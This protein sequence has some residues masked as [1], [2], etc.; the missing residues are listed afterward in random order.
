MISLEQSP[1]L[2]TYDDI[3]K[4]MDV[5]VEQEIVLAPFM[6]TLLNGQ[7]SIRGIREFALQYSYYSRNFPRV[8]GTAIGAMK[9]EDAWWVPIADNLWDEGGRGNP[10]GYHSRLFHTFLVTAAPDVPTNEKFVPYYPVAPPPIEATDTFINFLKAAT[11]LEAM[12]AI[13]FGSEFFAG[14]VMGMIG[15][16]LKHPNY[17]KERTL[18]VTFWEAHAD[19]HEPRHYQLCKDVLL[20]FTHPEELQTI[21]RVGAYIARSEARMY[22]GMYERML[23]AK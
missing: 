13:G 18:N 2:N 22:Q 20:E 5:L 6:Q 4:A 3:E 10:R 9:P 1:R 17:N 23:M 12:A 8:L 19:S 16:G 7:F 11:P 21:Y 14:K 15:E